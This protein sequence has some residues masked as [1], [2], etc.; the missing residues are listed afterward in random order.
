MKPI[1]PL[2]LLML[3]VGGAMAQYSFYP[4]DDFESGRTEGWYRFGNV[5]MRV[6]EN[7]TLEVT[8]QI[9][10]SCGRY[11]LQLS[12]TSENWYVGGAGRELNID[13]TP[14]TRLQVDLYGSADGGKLKIE[15]FDDDNFN[16]SLE[17]DPQRDWLVTKDDK[18]VAEVPVLGPGFTRISIPFTAFR[19]EN[20]GSGNGIFD[21]NQQGGSGG[22]LKM[23]F[24]LLTNQPRGRAEVRVD[25]IL[26]TY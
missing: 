23:Q 10:E 16:F 3:I 14:F 5:A 25:N 15:L 11:A 26:F 9:A 18:W 24:I 20:P 6:V 7:P 13:G 4:V 21:P 17:Q 2:L 19:L 12:G 1:F 8:D 22:M